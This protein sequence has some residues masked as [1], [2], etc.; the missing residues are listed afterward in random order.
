[1]E[2]FDK[3]IV[4]ELESINRH[5]DSQSNINS[6]LA[7]YLNKLTKRVSKRNVITGIALGVLGYSLYVQAS[8]IEILA[9]EIEDLKTE[10]GE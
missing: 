6:K 4:M 1:M 7:G 8:K 5:L 3:L 10:K 9:K 2:E